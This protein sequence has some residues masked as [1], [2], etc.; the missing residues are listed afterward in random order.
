MTIKDLSAYLPYMESV[1]VVPVGLTKYRDGLEPLECFTKEDAVRVIETIENW[2]KKFFVSHGTHF[3][4]ASDEWYILAG[5]PFP[6]EERY[7]GY[8]QL[9]N[10]VGM[11][12][13]L[14]N[15]F[16][17]AF[18]EYK[19]KEE[20]TS[21]VQEK[22]VISVATGKLAYDMISYMAGQIMEEH[23]WIFIR[24]YEIRNDF[25]GEKVTV[26]GLLT[27]Q[28]IINQLK[29]KDLGETLLLP[30]NVLRSGEDVFL[31]DVTVSGVQ[32]ALQVKV[33]IVKSSGKDLVYKLLGESPEEEQ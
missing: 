12:R 30:E 18:N 17:E 15:E 8:L 20:I 5:L 32:T 11:M 26:S 6:E 10:G 21:S 3:I 19:A 31:D 29:D 27:G 9:E 7:D 14:C 33:D 24:V 13:L 25:F 28:D 16:E 23:P 2:Q 1:S 4:H 22:K